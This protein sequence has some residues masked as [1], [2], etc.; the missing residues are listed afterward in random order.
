MNDGPTRK[1][2]LERKQAQLQQLKEGAEG[3]L[4]GFGRSGGDAPTL[5][6]LC[7]SAGNPLRVMAG[8][9]S[10]ASTRGLTTLL[11]EIN[12]ELDEIAEELEEYAA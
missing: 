7:E 10:Y 2:L 6:A 1:D 12:A 8:I 4:N 11:E 9:L 5:D 3:F